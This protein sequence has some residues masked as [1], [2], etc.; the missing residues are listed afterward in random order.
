V[1]RR[2]GPSAAKV[3]AAWAER[4]VADRI[5]NVD[6]L[7]RIRCAGADVISAEFQLRVQ[8]GSMEG[9]GD[10]QADLFSE[11]AKKDL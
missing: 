11:R 3:S 6:V 2:K 8:R 5:L 10:E 9:I 4:W 7:D 1:K